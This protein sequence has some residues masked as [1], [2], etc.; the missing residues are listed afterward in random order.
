MPETLFLPD[1]CRLKFLLNGVL[2]LGLEFLQLGVQVA[3]HFLV[4]RL[5]IK[6]VHFL[7]VFLEVVEF[8]LV[9]VVVEVDELVALGAHTIVALHHVLGRIL[10]EVVVERL[11]P[12]GRLLAAKQGQQGGALDVVG[13]GAPARSRKVGA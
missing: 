8:P 5:A 2:V 3:G 10:V 1:L 13:D 12:V 7:G 11:A 9:D 6:V 4:A